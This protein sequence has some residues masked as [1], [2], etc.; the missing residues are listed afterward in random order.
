MDQ[1]F[2][3]RRDWYF[4]KTEIA[5]HRSPPVEGDRPSPRKLPQTRLYQ[6]MQDRSWFVIGVKVAASGGRIVQ[7]PCA[8][9]A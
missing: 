3:T 5:R 2:V 7:Y 1:E 8:L 9:D 4:G 6:G